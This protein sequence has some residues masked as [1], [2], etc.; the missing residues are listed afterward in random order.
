ML[1]DALTKLGTQ[2]M[3][4]NTRNAMIGIT[5]FEHM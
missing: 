1:A 5:V 3:L 4:E 2:N